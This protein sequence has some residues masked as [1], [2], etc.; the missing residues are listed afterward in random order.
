MVTLTVHLDD[1]QAEAIRS[2]MRILRSLWMLSERRRLN[3]Q[4]RGMLMEAIEYIEGVI[5]PDV[6]YD[7]EDEAEAGKDA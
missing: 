4:E 5:D 3:F 1:E 7:D 6:C 2:H